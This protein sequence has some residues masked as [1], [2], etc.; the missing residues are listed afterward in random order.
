MDFFPK[1]FNSSLLIY[2][3][4]FK[5]Y[6]LILAVLVPYYGVYEPLYST[7][8]FTPKRNEMYV[9]IKNLHINSHNSIIHNSQKGKIPKCLAIDEQIMKM[10]YIY[11]MEYY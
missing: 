4:R 1:S 2:Q 3:S 6:Q 10:G 9:H 8:T 5:I 11:I 7:P